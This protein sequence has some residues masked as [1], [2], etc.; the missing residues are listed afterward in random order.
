L[1]ESYVVPATVLARAAE[2]L[3]GAA[4]RD[5]QRTVRPVEQVGEQDATGAAPVFV[6]DRT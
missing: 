4:A 6:S 3:R 2:R 1:L 5:A